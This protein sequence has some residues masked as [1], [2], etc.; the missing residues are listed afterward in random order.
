MAG[1]QVTVQAQSPCSGEKK[2]G[3]RVV[4]RERSAASYGR[5]LTLLLQKDQTESV[6]GLDQGVLTLTLPKRGVRSAACVVRRAQCGMRS[7]AQLTV[8]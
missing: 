3:E 8:S 7:A 4:Y 1:R 2:E 5:T 6:T